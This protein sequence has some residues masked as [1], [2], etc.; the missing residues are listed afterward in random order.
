MDGLHRG[1]RCVDTLYH[2]CWNAPVSTPAETIDFGAKVIDE[3]GLIA[4]EATGVENLSRVDLVHIVGGGYINK[5]WPQHLALI[6]AARGLR[7]RHGTRTAMTGA[8]LMPF[9]PGSE[10]SGGG[11]AG[12][13]R[14]GG[15]KGHAHA[16]EPHLRRPT[17]GDGRRRRIVGIRLHASGSSTDLRIRWRGTDDAVPAVGHAGDPS[18]GNRR[19]RRAHS[20]RSGESTKARSHWWSATPRTTPQ[21]LRCCDRTCRN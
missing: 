1:L 17:H 16:L 13:V 12:R 4:R 15:R 2:A 20:S 7:K 5:F 14:P 11:G 21:L 6:G 19:L 9:V 10:A 3:P 8:G 18:R